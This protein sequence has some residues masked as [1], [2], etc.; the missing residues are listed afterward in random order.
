MAYEIKKWP[1]TVWPDEVEKEC[2]EAKPDI[3]VLLLKMKEFGPKPEGYKLKTLGKAKAGLW[4][5]N[6]K[7]Q[8]KQIR[9]LYGPYG[10]DIVLF[11]IHKK[12]SPQEQDRAYELASKR[13]RDFEAMIDSKGAKNEK[14]P[15]N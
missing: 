6:L 2:P 5:I 15:N 1:D 3:S 8:K 11:R 4:Q 14:S 9:I 13:K 12:S 10:K 7:V